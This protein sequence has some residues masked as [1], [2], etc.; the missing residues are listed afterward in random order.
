[1][2]QD[3]KLQC[4]EIL[5]SKT[6]IGEITLKIFVDNYEPHKLMKVCIWILYE[7]IKEVYINKS[8]TLHY[9]KVLY[10]I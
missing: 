8:E 1:M 3:S 6:D 7:L 2:I 4:V 10:T 9:L 5:N